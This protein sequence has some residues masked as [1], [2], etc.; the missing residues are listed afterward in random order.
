MTIA[1]K[2]ALALFVA[3][4]SLA[5]CS[6]PRT[7]D[8]AA[9]A[10]ETDGGELTCDERM[11]AQSLCQSALLQRCET[12]GNDCESSC[13]ARGGLPANTQKVPSSRGD[14]ESTQCRSNCR[15]VRDACVRTVAQRCPSPCE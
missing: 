12:Q 11:R 1:D 8:A 9:S 15:Q 7:P 3:M 5:A 14:M 4:G 10:T 6:T 2:A 13:E